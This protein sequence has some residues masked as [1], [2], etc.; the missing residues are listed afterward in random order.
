MARVDGPRMKSE[1]KQEE[2]STE[3]RKRKDEIERN[4]KRRAHLSCG[5]LRS[6][7]LTFH[8]EGREERQAG[9][10]GIDSQV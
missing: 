1:E 3:S 10:V 9:A 8:H 2:G 6:E 7:V 5:V 4:G